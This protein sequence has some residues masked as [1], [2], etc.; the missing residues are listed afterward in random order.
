[1]VRVMRPTVPP[2][3][4]PPQ[5]IGLLDDRGCSPQD[6]P[7]G[8]CAYGSGWERLEARVVAERRKSV[9]DYKAWTHVFGG[10]LAA[11]LVLGGLALWSVISYLDAQVAL[12]DVCRFVAREAVTLPNEA[13]GMGKPVDTL[14]GA[15]YVG[16]EQ[17]ALPRSRDSRL[18]LQALR[19]RRRASLSLLRWIATE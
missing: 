7:E 18:M 14:E 13:I 11:C 9:E 3:P 19:L 2:R 4:T 10:L 12:K 1:M 6:T 17:D 15:Y 8:S 16:F 5:R